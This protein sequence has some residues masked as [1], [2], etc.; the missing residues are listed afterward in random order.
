MTEEETSVFVGDSRAWA[1]QQF[2]DCELGDVRRTRRVME[3]AARQADNPSGS[4]NAVCRGD[5][6]AAE[7]AYRM[8][9]NSDIEPDALEQGPFELTARRCAERDVVLAI[10]D[11]MTLTVSTA[12]GESL[13]EIGKDEH[14]G[15]GLLVHSTLAVDGST[16]EP[17]GLLDQLRWARSDDRPGKKTRKTRAYEEKE[18]FKWE[19]SSRA[20]AGRVAS[21]SNIV[22]VCDREADIYEFLQHHVELEQRF[23]VRAMQDRV[24]ESTDG[25]LWDHLSERPI[26]GKYEVVIQQRGGQRSQRGK[27]QRKRLA[28]QQRTATMAI[29]TATLEL[30]PP[31]DSRSDGQPIAVNVVLAQEEDCPEGTKPLEWMLLTSE[32]VSTKKAA[33]TVLRYYEFRWLIEEFH[34]AWKSGCRIEHRPVQSVGNLHRIIII[35]AQVAVR[36]LQLRSAATSQPELSCEQILSQDELQCLQATTQPAKPAQPTPPTVLWAVQAIGKLAGW[37]DTKRTG[38]VGWDMLWRGWMILEERVAGWKLA[39]QAPP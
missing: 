34:K 8:I 37:R 3:Y 38:R 14:S 35:T 22:T 31:R 13:G 32:A 26:V 19:T 1:E 7:G 23:V 36:L 27:C 12:L 28:R 10:Q 39:R 5:A 18:S 21:M 11:T 6:A 4:T 25:R 30:P 20:I 29:R 17:I 16:G 33:T 2:G 24:L 15:R 9:R